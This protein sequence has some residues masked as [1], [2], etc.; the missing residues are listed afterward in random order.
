MSDNSDMKKRLFNNFKEIEKKIDNIPE[1]DKV[2]QDTTLLLD[3][4]YLFKSHFSTNTATTEDGIPIAGISGV[5]NNIYKFV[6]RFNSQ[7][8]ICIFDGKKSRKRRRE[9]LESYKGNRDEQGNIRTPFDLN[10]N[11]LKDLEKLQMRVLY[12]LIGMMPVKRLYFEEL[13]ADDVIGYIT[14]TFF[15]DKKGRRVI[16]SEDRDFYQ[17]IDDHTQ[18]YHPRKKLLV[19]RSNFRDHWDTIPENVIYYRIIE[20]DSSD[21]IK[22]VKGWGTKTIEK[23]FPEIKKEK[24]ESFEDFDQLIESKR[25]TLLNTKTGAKIINQKEVLPDNFKLM[26]LTQ[27]MLTPDERLKVRAIIEKKVKQSLNDFYEF[28]SRCDELNL[29]STIYM[30]SMQ[31]LFNSLKY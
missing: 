19:G 9:I 10:E 8:V 22:G 20:G 15:R 13:E 16:V 14:K 26:D 4:S 3:I 11:S 30:R 25:G 2:V 6:N 29:S 23:F 12:E 24:I 31:L 1:E 5:I 17:L 27:T 21:N 18:V 7:K 28:K